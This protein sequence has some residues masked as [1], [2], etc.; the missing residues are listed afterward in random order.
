MDYKFEIVKRTFK[1]ESGEVREYFAFE[2]YLGGKTFSL[3]ARSED[4]RLINYML[5]DKA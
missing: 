2:L 4:K 1:T 5:E 3:L